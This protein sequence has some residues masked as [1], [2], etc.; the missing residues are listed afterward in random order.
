MSNRLKL[1]REKAVRPRR[2]VPVLLDGDVVQ[3]IEAVEAEL[4]RLDDPKATVADRRLSTKGNAAR[5]AEL[6]AESERLRASAAEDTIYVVLQGLPDT[7]W[8]AL[9]KKHP[10]AADVAA[11][12]A[13]RYGVSARFNIDTIRKPLVKACI[14]GH[15]ESDDAAAEL[16]TTWPSDDYVDWLLDF[17]S[18]GQLKELSDAAYDLCE[19]ADA[20]PL[21]RQRSQTE[22]SASA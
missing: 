9:K 4:D 19:R 20:V 21:P 3:Q 22:T 1:L 17:V 13:D 8:L 6:K 7:P 5:I 11:T 18:T 16:V 15:R 14:I 10:P 12:P 2:T